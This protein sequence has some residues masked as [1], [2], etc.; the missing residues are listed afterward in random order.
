MNF[1][2]IILLVGACVAV[3]LTPG[4]SVM[5]VTSI[6]AAR[7][8]RAA[9]FAILGM[10]VGAFLHVLLAASG[11]VTLLAT[12]PVL[13]TLIR[14]LGAAYLVYL[15]LDL[16][17]RRHRQ[18]SGPAQDVAA[19]D[20]KYFVRGLLVDALNPKIA[21]FF[22]AFIPQFLHLMNNPGFFM[23]LL[24]GSVF[25]VTGFVV[26]LGYAALAAYGSRRLR[27]PLAELTGR[28]L[29]AAVLIYLGLRLFWHKSW[30]A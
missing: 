24:P 25:L 20:G 18:E 3:N 4:P 28:W 19:N 14:Y 10:N 8:F 9:L 12:A 22:V 6:G 5:L 16:L 11:L 30:S 27:G 13:Y 7:G 23:S 15:G 2:Q 17:R 29:P 1:D 21:L 26:N